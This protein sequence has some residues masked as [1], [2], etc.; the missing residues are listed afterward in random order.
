M[1]NYPP[2]VQLYYGALHLYYNSLLDLYKYSGA[3][4]L[5]KSQVTN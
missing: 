4:H 5:K 1:D 3:L 2:F